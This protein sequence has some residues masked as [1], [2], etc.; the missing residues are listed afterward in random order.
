MHL[1]VYLLLNGTLSARVRR[2]SPPRLLPPPR[3]FCFVSK[4]QGVQRHDPRSAGGCEG[5][6]AA[7]GVRPGR[8]P[9]R[10]RCSPQ[11]AL[12]IQSA[13]GLLLLKARRGCR[14]AVFANTPS[15]TC[16]VAPAKEFH[17]E[18]G[19]GFGRVMLLTHLHAGMDR[20]PGLTWRDV[21]SADDI[22][23]VLKVRP[24]PALIRIR[25]YCRRSYSPSPRVLMDTKLHQDDTGFYCRRLGATGRPPRRP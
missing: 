3:N 5:R 10:P 1:T 17:G 4:F 18:H 20:I 12:D 6:V 24:S 9:A 19:V 13:A 14:C 25:S 2:R 16:R 23:A 8:R 7:G 21:Q 15:E 11:A 22:T